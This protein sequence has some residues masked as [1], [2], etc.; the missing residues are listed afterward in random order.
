MNAFLY[1]CG[2]A[3]VCACWASVS[4][5]LEPRSVAV[6]DHARD[7]PEPRLASV[8]VA[9][10]LTNPA[11]LGAPPGDYGRLFIGELS[12][13]GGVPTRADVRILSLASG[14]LLPT[15]YLSITVST[16][17]EKGLLG[18]AFHPAYAANGNLYIHHSQAA[19]AGSR[20]VRYTVSGN[21]N[22]ANASS[23]AEVFFAPQTG[24]IHQGGWTGFGPDG[25]LYLALGELGSSSNSQNATNLFGKILRIDAGTIPYSIPPT[26]PFVGAPPARPEIW[27]MGLRNPW[28]CGFDG[29][30]GDLWIG[31]VGPASFEEINFQPAAGTP[32]FV[33]RNYG[34]PCAIGPS[35]GCTVPVVPPVHYWVYLPGDYA[36]GGYVYRGAAVP[37]LRGS[38]F[39]WRRG[40]STVWTLRYDGQQVTELIN[41]TAELTPTG[42]A[43]ATIVSF[44]EDAS[45]EVYMASLGQDIVY[46]I[47]P[48][49]RANCDGSAT[50]PVLTIDDFACF[51]AKFLGA[52]PYA[53]CNEDNALTIADFGCFQ[54]KFVAGCP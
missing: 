21:P 36:V 32:P 42:G 48:R 40:D 13:S 26:N 43:L 14:L 29:L 46:K 45:G 6:E 24:S 4:A 8:P 16:S 49:C 35:N 18:M 22:V 34:W 12:G 31:D 2:P 50:A 33:A 23:A 19:P 51:T 10:G 52:D 37:E 30:T 41:R 11:V 39:F 38:Y 53:D 17:G 25:Y 7:G 9:T 28:R 44:G 5:G 15:P 54:T 27:A 47:V 1:P 20:I 3:A